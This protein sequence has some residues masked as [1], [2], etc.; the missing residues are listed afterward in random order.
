MISNERFKILIKN[1]I[2][3]VDDNVISNWE[4][5]AK[6]QYLKTEIGFTSRELEELEIEDILSV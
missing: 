4:L 6:L 2:I 1:L 5:D 3:E